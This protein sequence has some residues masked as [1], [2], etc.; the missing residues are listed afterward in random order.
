MCSETPDTRTCNTCGTEKLL[1]KDNFYWRSDNQTFRR[2]CKTCFQ[3]AVL[4]RRLQVD[5]KFYHEALS[6]QNH[7]CAICGSK[8][9]SSR[10]TKFAIDHCH[11]SG[12]VRGLL[13]THCNTGIG[14]FKESPERLSAALRYLQIH[15]P[16]EDIV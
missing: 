13:C 7:C 3:E 4:K 1:T 8:L 10:Y 11:R 12:K 2:E 5:F 9:N 6:R 14:L 15:A 16:G